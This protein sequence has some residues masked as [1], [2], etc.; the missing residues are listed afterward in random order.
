MN[1]PAILFPCHVEDNTK[2]DGELVAEY[3]AARSFGFE[4]V[5]YDHFA[6]VEGQVEKALRLLP[7]MEDGTRTVM[8]GWMVSG[9]IYEKLYEGLRDRGFEPEVRPSA[10]EQAHYLPLAYALIEGETT[11]SEW[12][13]GD[14]GERAWEMYEKNF[15]E[16]DA[17][18]K[19]WV[20]SA[21]KAWLEGCYIPAGTSKERFLEIYRTFRKV[22]G[23]LFNR[24]VVLREFMPIVERGSDMRGLPIVEETRLFFWHG[25]ILVMPSSGHPCAMDERSRWEEIARRFESPF[26]TIDV[27]YLTDGSWQIVEVGDGGVSGL[28][29]GLDPERFYGS[30]WNHGVEE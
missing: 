8:R 15:R 6:L 18:M 16:G 19:D 22:R 12:F 9:E 4:T 1:A 25:K 27:A 20:K 21:K 11:R 5:F 14:D 24:G 7:E 28:P 13:E 23:K 2:V 3:E 17:V 29:V 10:Y 30:L 26:M